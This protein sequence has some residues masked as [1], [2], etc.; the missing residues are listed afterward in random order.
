[1]NQDQVFRQCA[2]TK[3]ILPRSDLFRVVRT[4]RGQI[5]FDPEYKVL[6]RGIHFS[7]NL[8]TVEKFFNPR[9]R[10]MVEHF[11]Q[12]GISENDFSRLREEALG[13]KNF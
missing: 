11:L 7:K 1:M 5:F 8:E 3:K 4:K 9:K 12:A 6:G 10:K 2:I 13:M